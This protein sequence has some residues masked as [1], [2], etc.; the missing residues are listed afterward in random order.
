MIYYVGVNMT[1]AGA[2][3]ILTTMTL[4]L[5]AWAGSVIFNHSERLSVIETSKRYDDNT[6]TEI[7]NDVKEIKKALKVP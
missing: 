5:A 7:K 2:V 1:K 6:L 4:G 3:A